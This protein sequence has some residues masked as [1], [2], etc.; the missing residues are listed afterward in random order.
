MTLIERFLDRIASISV[1][2][3]KQ[4]RKALI[5]AY[6][7][8][9]INTLS[10]VSEIKNL[11]Y[12]QKSAQLRDIFVEPRLSNGIDILSSDDVLLTAINGT[13][14]VVRGS[15]GLG[16]SVLLKHFCLRHLDNSF[17]FAPMFVELRKIEAAS[18]DSILSV[19]HEIYSRDRGNTTK[20]ELDNALKSR[21]FSV[22]LDGFD[23]VKPDI[24]RRVEAAILRFAMDYPACPLIVSGRHDRAFEAWE[25]FQVF[26]MMPMTEE[27]TVELIS[28]LE[29]DKETKTRFLNDAVPKLFSDKDR[30]FV[31]TPL[32]A[33]LMLLTYEL[34]AEVPDKMHLFYANAFETLLRGH[35]V[36]K[37]QFRR[38]LISG[39]TEEGFKKLFSAFCAITYS[40]RKYEFSFDQIEQYIIVALD[41]SSVDAKVREIIDDL[42]SSVCV[43]QYESLEYSFVH[44]SFQEYFTAVYLRES[45]LSVVKS[46]LEQG[47]HASIE[48]VVP[49]LIG[50]DRDRIEDEWCL[51]MLEMLR[52]A[53][54]AETH[55]GR[56]LKFFSH[57]YPTFGCGMR[58]GGLN[59]LHNP[60]SDLMKRARALELIYPASP[61]GMW[62]IDNWDK[63]F[64]RALAAKEKV[65]EGV[66]E[67]S[68]ADDDSAHLKSMKDGSQELIL[69]M[70]ALSIDDI[71]RLEFNGI[72]NFFLSHLDAVYLEVKDRVEKRSSFS[73][74][75]FQKRKATSEGK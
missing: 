29:Y 27:A 17:D 38:P 19:L 23:E 53:V 16:K 42:I 7:P 44:R 10:R 25:Q 74:G 34:F 48:N 33:I 50:M 35:D 1:D 21:F 6:R 4:L 73:K 5:S 72:A 2:S 24:Q 41:A 62:W 56:I 45:P 46:F 8:E 51:P 75:L 28:K 31:Q 3:E 15:A 13:R 39:V 58:Q 26:D 63:M 49:M 9:L 55:D 40:E 12:R 32:L 22:I 69:S 54:E 59:S 20:E 57:I 65:L 18:S 43:M 47:F 60:W 14:V 61:M 66:I 70:S 67:G 71:C 37:S 11:L 68:L 52:S 30:S 64:D 36:T